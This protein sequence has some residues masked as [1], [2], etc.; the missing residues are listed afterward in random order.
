[1]VTSF[2]RSDLFRTVATDAETRW[3]RE[4]GVVTS[5]LT[6]WPRLRDSWWVF[7]LAGA[8]IMIFPIALVVEIRCGRNRCGGTWWGRWFELDALGSLPRLYTTGL[9]AA[10]AVIAWVAV[11]RTDARVRSWW[12]AVAVIGVVLAVAKLVSAHSAAK[13][14]SALATLVLSVSG[15]VVALGAL[16]LTGRRWG[17]AAARPV[18]IAMGLY[19]F[20]SL[21]LDAVSMM[22]VGAQDRVGLLSHVAVTF[23]EELG[24]AVA[25]LFLLVTV[26]WQVPTADVA[27]STPRSRG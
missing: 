23:A 3:P 13:E 24:E 7:T 9:F 5:P 15:T 14:V 20:A 19:A 11:R 17:V 8:A 10:V 12:V 22:L 6:P 25:A 4:D 26:R 21:G 1:M 27:L 16:T 18:V 2:P